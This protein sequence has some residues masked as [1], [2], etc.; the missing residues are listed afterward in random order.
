MCVYVSSRRAQGVSEIPQITPLGDGKRAVVCPHGSSLGPCVN[1]SPRPSRGL[2][3][4]GNL[5]DLKL[6]REARGDSVHG[7]LVP[8]RGLGSSLP[9]P[10][11][12]VQYSGDF[13]RRIA[14][15]GRVDLQTQAVPIE[16][17]GRLQVVDD[18]RDSR[19]VPDHLMFPLR[20]VAED[21][22]GRK[23]W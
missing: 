5:V 17:D 11:A 3:G 1:C 6:D 13:D 2:G 21:R 10:D 19:Q 4:G 20:V 12:E 23:N 14:G 8:E 16:A 22:Y 9:A 7:R 15:F 18:F